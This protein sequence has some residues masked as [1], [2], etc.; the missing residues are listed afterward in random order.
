MFFLLINNL[1]SSLG[2]INELCRLSVRNENL[3]VLKY[4]T[5]YKTYSDDPYLLHHACAQKNLEI[6]NYVLN[7]SK[8]FDEIDQHAETPLHWAVMRGSYH[9]VSALLKV[10]KENHLD[11]NINSKFGITP[12]HLAMLKQDKHLVQLLFEEGGD[13]NEVDCEGNSIVHMLAAIGD[14]KWIKYIVKNFNAHCFQKNKIGN[15]PFVTAILNGRIEVVEYFLQ[16]LPNLNWKNKFGQTPLHA[17]VYANEIVIVELLL[18]HKADLTAKDV[19][20]LTPYHYAYVE[21]KSEMIK[22]I[23]C[24]LNVDK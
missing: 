11:I 15:T 10:L 19:N 17:A 22:I 13:V 23:H 24:V 3:E 18:K 20:D 21:K 5:V 7:I 4:L 1:N 12:F 14:L 16:L 6:F 9:I 2:N 8:K